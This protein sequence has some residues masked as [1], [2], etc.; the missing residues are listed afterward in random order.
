M[1]GPDSQLTKGLQLCS[2]ACSSL[3]SSCALC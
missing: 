2:F 1:I 3:L